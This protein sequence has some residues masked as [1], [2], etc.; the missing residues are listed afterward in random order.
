MKTKFTSISFYTAIALICLFVMVHDTVTGQNTTVRSYLKQNFAVVNQVA[1][2]AIEVSGSAMNRSA[3]PELPVFGE[4]FSF[5]GSRGSS[6][7]VSIIN[8]QVSSSVTYSYGILP[9]KEG[10]A[11]I[12][13]I[14]IRIGGQDYYSEPLTVEI[15]NTGA[16]PQ[17]QVRPGL[18]TPRNPTQQEQPVDIHLIAD[19]DKE[20]VY[21]NQGITVEYKVY[22]GPGVTIR[23]YSP[24]NTP[25]TAGFWTEEYPMDT[26]P[27]AVPEFYNGKQYNAAVLQKVELFSTNSGDFELD[28]KEMKFV[29]RLPNRSR[30]IFDNLDSFFDNPFS[31]SQRDISVRSNRL[32]ITVKP[33]P[34]EGRPSYFAG[35]V[36]DYTINADVDIARVKVHDSIT[37][38]VTVNGTGNI[39]LINEPELN[40]SGD[41]ERYDPKISENITRRGNEISGEKKFEYVLIPRRAG[42]YTLDTISFVYFNPELETYEIVTTTPI[43][44]T[45]NP[46]ETIAGGSVHNLTR[47][48]I[49][50]VGQDI[51]FIKESA[52]QW[53]ETGRWEYMTWT[54]MTI[55]FSPVIL[56]FVGLTYSRH[57]DRLQKDTGYKR[58][59]QAS[60][61]ANKRLKQAHTHLHKDEPEQFYPEVARAL[62]EYIADKL[63]ISAAGIVADELQSLLTGKN[64]DTDLTSE[65][66]ACLKQC[67]FFRFS[68]TGSSQ[69]EMEKLYDRSKLAILSLEERMRKVA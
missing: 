59:R 24:I 57:L 35:A 25:N 45:V 34:V 36:G 21:Q 7:S 10:T 2:L 30:N 23:E 37:M 61:V 3:Q 11:T 22:F 62:Q 55:L 41:F 39:K 12:P 68:T 1:D 9:L 14:K 43:S 56:F 49:R 64:I 69:R 46:G 48:E 67:D 17:Q 51:R 52:S 26:S 42:I 29:V 54:F 8:G 38:T 60:T 31:S 18:R 65:Y 66:I 50:L 44:L 6:Q 32:N 33:L 28:P 15:K 63:N 13:R 47:E 40:L 4:W 58:S 19:V 5:A 16:A 20:T 27:R 53:Y